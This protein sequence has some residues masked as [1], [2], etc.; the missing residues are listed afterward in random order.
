MSFFNR[1]FSDPND[2]DIRWLLAVALDG[3]LGIEDQEQRET[4][5][6]HP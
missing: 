1:T 2:S 6:S 5:I 3:V 4:G